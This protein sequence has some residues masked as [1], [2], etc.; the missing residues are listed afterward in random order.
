MRGVFLSNTVE[1]NCNWFK[2][3]NKYIH[4]RSYGNEYLS[5]D[6]NIAEDR[7]K[8]NVALDKRNYKQNHKILVV[9]E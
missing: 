6:I 3:S 7:D 2:N 5:N 8:N 4:I 1:I 9:S